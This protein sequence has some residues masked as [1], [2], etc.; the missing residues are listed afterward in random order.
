MALLFKVPSST[1]LNYS[2]LAYQRASGG[3]PDPQPQ[4]ACAGLVTSCSL[5]VLTPGLTLVARLRVCTSAGCGDSATVTASVPDALPTGI[6]TPVVIAAS[7]E[8]GPPGTTTVRW[9]TPGAPNS[10]NMT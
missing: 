5:P 4:V 3:A 10:A 7:A 2:L 8:Q 9:A 6:A 1:V